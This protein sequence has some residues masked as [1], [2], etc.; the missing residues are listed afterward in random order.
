MA[1]ICPVYSAMPSVFYSC[2]L[3]ELF[4]TRR[5]HCRTPLRRERAQIGLH[6]APISPVSELNR[7][8]AEKQQR[9]LKHAA[10]RRVEKMQRDLDTRQ[11][12]GKLVQLHSVDD[13]D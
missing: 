6:A 8:K 4:V 5:C 10:S 2:S 9:K 11:R 7:R 1:F 12:L 3:S 13:D